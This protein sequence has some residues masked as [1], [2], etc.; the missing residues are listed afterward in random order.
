MKGEI[1]FSLLH[2]SKHTQMHT[3]SPTHTQTIRRLQRTHCKYL[4]FIILILN[5][6]AESRY[7]ALSLLI[8][9]APTLQF[10]L[11][12]RETG[13]LDLTVIVNK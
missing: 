6:K 3:N 8:K 9:I 11:F 4:I 12:H 13:R 5:L 1:P 10:N 7:E 2:M